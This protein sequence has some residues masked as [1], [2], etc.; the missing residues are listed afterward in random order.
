MDKGDCTHNVQICFPR[1]ISSKRFLV[2]QM[3]SRSLPTIHDPWWILGTNPIYAY[4]A[5]NF[6]SSAALTRWH[7]FNRAK[8]A[9]CEPR[10]S[11]AL[12]AM[13]KRG[14]FFW[15]WGQRGRGNSMLL[16][17]ACGLVA[18]GG[19]LGTWFRSGKNVW[20]CG[21]GWDRSGHQ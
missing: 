4:V 2:L 8:G 5:R 13:H 17:G 21:R 9:G 1:I 14:A 12:E 16:T 19:N 3:L 10:L 7:P 6:L 18:L 20:R 11:A 15:S